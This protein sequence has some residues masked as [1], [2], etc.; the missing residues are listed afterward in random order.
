MKPLVSFSRLICSLGSMQAPSV[1]AMAASIALAFALPI[2]AQ[3]PPTAAWNGPW[4]GWLETPSQQLRLVVNLQSASSE[5]PAQATNTKAPVAFTGEVLSPDQSAAAYALTQAALESDGRFHF[6]VQPD[7][8]K[9][10]AYSFSGRSLSPG[11][12]SGELE[13][14]GVKIPLTL[15]K[16][17]RLPPEGTDR[18]GAD[19]AWIGD[20]D[21]GGRKVPL[22]LR[23]YRTPPYA[24]PEVPRVLLDSILEKANG[25]PVSV[26][27]ADKDQIEFSIPTIPGKAKYT[28]SLNKAGDTLEGRF[29]QGFLPLSLSMKRVQEFAAQ[30]IE[31]DA[32]VQLLKRLK[33]DAPPATQLPF[34]EDKPKVSAAVEPSMTK[35]APVS[36]PAKTKLPGGIREEAFTV[37]VPDYN[38]P[39]IKNAEGRRVH[40]THRISGTITWPRGSSESSRVPAV[41]MI[42]DS[43]PHDRDA[44][45]GPHRPFRDIAHFLA[46]QGVASLRYDDRGIAQSTGDFI[47]SNSQDFADDAQAV[48]KHASTLPAIDGERLGMLGH[49]EGAIVATMVASWSRDIAYLILL[50]PPGLRGGEALR[51]QLD[52]TM[53]LQGVDDSMRTAASK[54]QTAM[55]S[56]ALEYDPGDE[57]ANREVRLWVSNKWE[58]LKALSGDAP[59]SPSAPPV[60]QRVI[61]GIVREFQTLRTPWMQFYLAYDPAPNW[62]LIKCPTLAIWGDNDVMVMPAATVK[63]LR[64][65]ASRNAALDA[66]LFVLPELNHWLQT[67]ESGLPEES[68]SLQEAIAPAALDTISQWLRRQDL[69][70]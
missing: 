66:Q 13:Q 36:E 57:T 55:Q 32:L 69:S 62:M 30:P 23:V 33:A 9:P 2:Q 53:E 21:I 35:D 28:A 56:F 44:T 22:R 41:V 67:S 61:E 18:L 60:K 54:L 8:N 47:N 3:E 49:G 15:R 11:T 58:Q 50:S 70:Q 34:A 52:R 38:Q 37:E 24:T 17:D 31:K 14:S 26:A 65:A 1:M 29:Q 4:I 40:A 27:L 20:L 39:K 51:A 63:R 12:V 64:E 10:E 45:N 59:A 16:I 68:P 19:S 42:A 5:D 6:E 25:F 48:W 46:K 7:P 43:G